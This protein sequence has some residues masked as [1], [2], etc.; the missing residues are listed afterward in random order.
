VPLVVATGAGVGKSE[1]SPV[2][3][4]GRNGHPEPLA[5]VFHVVHTLYDYY[6]RI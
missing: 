3:V 4:H 6:E 1:L 5:T 2:T